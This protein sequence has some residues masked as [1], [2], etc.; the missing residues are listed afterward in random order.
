MVMEQITGP[1]VDPSQNL[2]FAPL[3]I[4]VLEN[5]APF[6]AIFN[7]LADQNS[8]LAWQKLV[9]LGDMDFSLCL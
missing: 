3:L 2:V 8:I 4:I 9:V 1:L 7:T 6:W 5:V